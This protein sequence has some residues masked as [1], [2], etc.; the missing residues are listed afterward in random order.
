MK[1][2]TLILDSINANISS[3]SSTVTDSND[4]E[5]LYQSNK[6]LCPASI[7]QN[8]NT[9]LHLERA[10]YSDFEEIKNNYDV[11]ALE[12]LLYS[13]L[14]E[15]KADEVKS[16]LEQFKNYSS[17]L[18]DKWKKSFSKSSPKE[19]AV[20]SLKKNEIELEAKL[21]KKYKKNYVSQWV[22]LTADKIVASNKS[23]SELKKEL[24][25]NNMHNGITFLKL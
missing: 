14:K 1:E 9:Y 21:I 24:Q 8:T 17:P 2:D 7:D 3:N 23:L 22:A 20:A 15:G 11:K 12:Q 4:N 18:I 5:F 10:N 25:S 16:I 19:N 13:L 6:V